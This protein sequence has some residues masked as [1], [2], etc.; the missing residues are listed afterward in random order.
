[1]IRKNRFRKNRRSRLSIVRILTLASIAIAFGGYFLAIPSAP[2]KVGQKEIVSKDITLPGQA[3]RPGA[4]PIELLQHKKSS[5]APTAVAP[6]E[7]VLQESESKSLPKQQ[8][9]IPWKQISVAP[10]DNMSLIFSRLKV[11]SANLLDIVSNADNK[12]HFRNIKPGQVI[13]FKIEAREVLSMVMELDPLNHLRIVKGADTYHSRI[14]TIEPEI[15]LATAA[16][17][18]KR[19]LFIDG[20]KLGLSDA[21]ILKL[22]DIFGWDIDFALDLRV[23]DRFSLIYEKIYKDGNF[24]KNGRILAAE[25]V[26]RGKPIRAVLYT[27]SNGRTDYY[28]ESGLTMRKTFL[29][30]PVDFTRISSRFNLRRKHPILNRIRAHRGVD[31]AASIGTPVK[32]TAD[33][34]ITSIGRNGGYGRTVEMKHGSN[35]GTLYAHLSRYARGMKKGKNIAQGQIIG[36]VGKSG[37]ATGPHLHYELR[38]NGLHKNPLTVNFPNAETVAE[39]NLAEFKKVTSPLISQLGKIGTELSERNSRVDLVANMGLSKIE[40][41]GE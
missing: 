36:Y 7:N 5:L 25:F 15:R 34:K 32:A 40:T 16:G 12:R 3:A 13:R 11:S 28:S 20:Q 37:L 10:G 31:Y 14:E 27:N 17:V 22:T 24:L 4:R 1:M 30:N 38:V 6:K 18:I 19:S 9:D 21:M 8:V 2:D 35:Y 26:N 41:A 23:N 29:R 39:K 33:G